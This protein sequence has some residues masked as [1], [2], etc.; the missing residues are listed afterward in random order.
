MGVKETIRVSKKGPF[1]LKC[2][3]PQAAYAM[4]LAARI[5]AIHSL[6]LAVF[7][8]QCDADRITIAKAKV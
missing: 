7:F 6:F 1:A 8:T 4:L 2:N 3:G 5:G